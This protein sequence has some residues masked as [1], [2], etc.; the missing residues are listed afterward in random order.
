M[1]TQPKYKT[2]RDLHLITPFQVPKKQCQPTY[3]CEH[4]YL[5]SLTCCIKTESKLVEQY[6][7]LHKN[8][9]SCFVPLL[10]YQQNQE[11]DTTC[12][13]AMS[14][15]HFVVVSTCS[16]NVKYSC[17]N[18]AGKGSEQTLPSTSALLACPRNGQT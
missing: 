16:I 9:C 4:I 8:V 5:T 14:I 18:Q 6:Q 7:H 1:E 2:F 3:Q 12:N 15:L 13:L 11:G 10:F 17:W